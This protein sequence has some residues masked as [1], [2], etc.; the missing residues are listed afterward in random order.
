M[1]KAIL[2]YFHAFRFLYCSSHMAVILTSDLGQGAQGLVEAWFQEMQLF[3]SAQRPG[4]TL[5][6]LRLR[7]LEMDDL[8]QKPDS[9]H[10]AIIREVDPK[11]V[12][13]GETEC[14]EYLSQSC[15]VNTSER[16]FGELKTF[17]GLSAS[18]PAVVAEQ[19]N[20][21][22]LYQRRAR[23][24]A[25]KDHQDNWRSCS[26]PMTP[27][28][29]PTIQSPGSAQLPGTQ[30]DTCFLHI[31][32]NLVNHNHL[33]LE[34]E[35]ERL[36]H[37][38]KVDLASLAMVM[39]LNTW[40][41]LLDFFGI[42]STAQ[43]HGMRADLPSRSSSLNNNDF[44]ISGF[45]SVIESNTSP[46]HGSI[47]HLSQVIQ[48]D[49]VQNNT[50]IEL[51]VGTLSLLLNRQEGEVARAEASQLHC[52][53]STHGGDMDLRGIVSDVTLSDRSPN[54]TLYP[55]RLVISGNGALTFHLFRFGLP[56][57]ELKRDC[58]AR[59]VVHLA[60]ALLLH[61]QRFYMEI[62]STLHYFVQLQELLGRQR[63]ALDGQQ[64][65]CTPCRGMRLSV[66]LDAKS[67]LLLFPESSL[68]PRLLA[69]SVEHMSIRNEFRFIGH[70]GLRCLVDA[71]LVR[72]V[73][74]EW[75][76]AQHSKVCG[77][78]DEGIIFPSFCVRRQADTLLQEKLDLELNLER[79]LDRDFSRHVPDMSVHGRMTNTH[80][81][82][83]SKLYSLVHAVLQSNLGE[84]LGEP[85]RPYS[86]Q[87][88]A[89][90][91]VLSGEVFTTFLLVLSADNVKLDLLESSGWPPL[92]FARFG[93][94]ESQLSVTS[95]SNQQF[96]VDLVSRT[97]HAHDTRK[98]RRPGFGEDH[99]ILEGC[100]DTS[101]PGLWQ[102]ELHSRESCFTIVL[103]NLRLLLLFPWL[104]DV[105]EFFTSSVSDEKT[106]D[107]SLDQ[108][109]SSHGSDLGPEEDGVWF[110]TVKSGVLTKRAT[111]HLSSKRSSKIKVNATGVELVLPIYPGSRDSPV[112]VL[113]ATAVVTRRPGSERPLSAS[114]ADL[115]L[116]S[117][118]LDN[119]QSSALSILDP[120]NLFIELNSCPAHA[121]SH[122]LLDAFPEN[123]TPPML[124]I[125]FSNLN[126]R[127]SYNDLKL[128]LTL[129]SA[130][131]AYQ[132]DLLGATHSSSDS[133]CADNQSQ[134]QASPPFSLSQPTF[135]CTK[136]SPAEQLQDLGFSAADCEIALEACQGQLNQAAQWLFENAE[137]MGCGQG[138]QELEWWQIS[139][140]ELDGGLFCVC[141]IDD[142]QDCDIPLAE[143]T[144]TGVHIVQR[145]GTHFEGSARLVLAV[146]YYNRQLSGWESLL[147]NWPAQVSWKHH[148]A[149]GLNPPRLDVS[150]NA[151][152]RLDINITC[153]LVDQL[154][155][156]W[157]AWLED[158]SRENGN[159]IV[160]SGSYV[161]FKSPGMASPSP[162]GQQIA[163]VSTRPTTFNSPQQEHNWQNVNGAAVR[164]RKS[165]AP[166]VLRNDTGCE[167]HF[168]TRISTPARKDGEPLTELSG[169]GNVEEKGKDGVP[170]KGS[171]QW[172]NVMPGD[173]VP[174]EFEGREKLRQR[175][176]HELK[177]HQVIV[178]VSG[179]EPLPPI[180]VDRV[181]IYFRHTVPEKIQT[182]THFSAFPAVRVVVA[183]A[184]EGSTRKMVTVRSALL[185]S[186]HL[187]TA[188]EL[189][190]DNPTAP[191]KPVVLSPVSP[192]TFLPV[193]LNLTQWRLQAR[194]PSHGLLFCRPPVHWVVAG[195]DG[196]VSAGQRECLALPGSNSPPF[197]F[198]V[199]VENLGFPQSNFDETL[200]RKSKSK[201]TSFPL[202][203]HLIHLL[204]TMTI[205]NLLPCDL[206]YY[207]KGTSTA[208]VIGPGQKSFLQSADLTQ[209][210]EL[211]ILLDNFPSCKEVLIPV[212]TAGIGSSGGS[213][214]GSGGGGTSLVDVWRS[215][216]SLGL[217]LQDTAHRS[218]TL[219]VH[220]AFPVEGVLRVAICAPYWLINKTGIPLIFRQENSSADA[221]GQFEEHE[222]ARSLTPL[223]FSYSDRDLPS[224]CTMRVGRGYH[225]NGSPGWCQA[226]SLEGGSGVRAV[227]VFQPGNRPG[228]V[229]NIGIDV[230]KGR[231]RYRHT[232]LVTFAPRYLLDN[233]SSETLLFS[234]REFIPPDLS[235]AL[236][237]G[238]LSTLPG[239]SAVFHWPRVDFE[240]LL[241]VRLAD[242]SNCSWSGAFQ[243]AHNASFCISMRNQEGG[244]YFLRVEITLKRATYHVVLMDTSQLPPPFRLDNL[245]EVPVVFWQRGVTDPCLRSEV[246][247]L[248]SLPFAP[249]EPTLP[250]FITCEVKGSG[251]SEATVNMDRFG[252]SQQLY[253]ENYI[254]V[255]S[256]HTFSGSYAAGS[257]VD[258]S[259]SE[260]VM[261]VLPRSATVV[262][263]RKEAGKR[264]QL[265]RLTG[266]GFLRHEGSS[267]PE[268]PRAGQTERIRS[269]E[270][271]RSGTSPGLVLDITGTVPGHEGSSEPLIIRSPDRR[272]RAT[273]TW[274]FKNG[275]LTCGLTG[276]VV[277]VQGGVEGL[278]EG[279]QLELAPTRRGVGGGVGV[280]AEQA[281][282]NQ[283]MRKGSG[284]LLL[285][286]VPD[287]PTRVLQVTDMKQGR[288]SRTGPVTTQTL[289]S[290]ENDKELPVDT[291][292]EVYV[293]MAGGVGISLI[294]GVRDSTEEVAFFCLR[295][296][297]VHFQ[298]TSAGAHSLE[299]S[300]ADVQVDN[301]LLNA[302]QEVVLS[303]ATS[304]SASSPRHNTR[305]EPQPALQLSAVKASSTSPLTDIFKRLMVSV[306]KL[307]V[308]LEERFLLKL[309][310]FFGYGRVEDAL[311][312]VG[313]G[314]VELCRSEPHGADRKRFYF[315]LLKLNIPGL[316]LSF[317]PASCLLTSK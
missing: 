58:D 7:G 69:A 152:K 245:A 178:W 70:D 99:P 138:E 299:V 195:N 202:A 14:R 86:L 79:N 122:G 89:T 140:V 303:V 126:M 155:K 251:S 311:E 307:T 59:L 127:L 104:S 186:N 106:Q 133:K 256:T 271:R 191:D 284:A 93:F 33:A 1:W 221:A 103:N 68:S 63:A 164:R 230:R 151:S 62:T 34:S 100:Q 46:G 280:A 252:E 67:L 274:T 182:D 205:C 115:E 238:C 285:Q 141:F 316:R 288:P 194:P 297:H 71:M 148:L 310:Q 196:D 231:G 308:N 171:K 257:P 92:S 239:A 263:R 150:V 293:K 87:E 18:L 8:L 177:S 75:F 181:G 228:L 149:I 91:T 189:R 291:E 314:V 4:H 144:L 2:N 237:P 180:S 286:I 300:V 56:D 216:Y 98:P 21:F 22:A 107:P 17:N 97:L 82:L 254:Y 188:M 301:Q 30:R 124:E 123:R 139:G 258:L 259:N 264:S 211:G 199:A 209:D 159:E 157:T 128:F 55:E 281:F 172:T 260:L 142:C 222:M 13:A 226:F 135:S 183:V 61:T 295:G 74:M 233:R 64:V 154:K 190:L 47:P 32:A 114:L 158:Y 137:A 208:G 283:K 296:V 118:R 110:R 136:A 52:V 169:T 66:E 160:G 201:V 78:N 129:T 287:G 306:R 305:S 219:I 309:L 277:Q 244:C 268:A 35:S 77:V 179:W 146:D 255:A 72:L 19:H 250:P 3:V 241:S 27:P 26:C 76:M 9:A 317:K 37:D 25:G 147:E 23:P 83:S 120:T 45:P 53:L 235:S 224:L 240:Q 161:G 242:R 51:Q 214:I 54:G 38:L 187:H 198:C 108:E 49:T 247:P 170:L 184:M 153:A 102:F 176:T 246:K 163:E 217:R 156:T 31:T 112:L 109:C 270:A 39:T 218:L 16:M 42:G 315:E 204:P 220:L 162:T 174:F 229:Y 207:I 48:D 213:N 117:C 90:H 73:A 50:R 29:S 130:L 185:V 234:Q 262:L 36:S 292:I 276:L 131:M 253:Y 143:L 166:F 57:P 278:H 125:Q 81:L 40:V 267:V 134:T 302:G 121:S 113:R 273:Q 243:L 168:I 269:V 210:I 261:D 101:I 175:H 60:P 84:Q 145:L 282:H 95:L 105:S 28:P 10:R 225:P 167:L 20:V 192:G 132:S 312:Y 193:P 24:K 203:G 279:A 96:S 215:G 227:Q 15:P 272:R 41:L 265:W 298:P 249:D 275:Q 119:E 289:R 88:P 212:H 236:P 11:A 206:S 6:D 290:T 65:R 294:G 43:N 5:L 223:V 197:R 85:S 165:C 248:T 304:T 200:S 173:E 111:A 94:G 266:D 232:L 44:L 12:K 313:E 116:F 80:I